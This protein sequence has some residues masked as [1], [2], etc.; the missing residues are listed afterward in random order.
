[1]SSHIRSAFIRL[2]LHSNSRTSERDAQGGTVKQEALEYQRLPATVYIPSTSFFAS[3]SSTTN[4]SAAN[5]FLFG[6][7]PAGSLFAT[8]L[9]RNPIANIIRG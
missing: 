1:M 3:L 4:P 5:T 9:T 6:F 7:L 2:I 8:L